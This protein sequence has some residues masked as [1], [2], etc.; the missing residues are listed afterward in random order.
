[1]LS[2]A[3]GDEDRLAEA[4]AFRIDQ[5]HPLLQDTRL[6]Q[7]FD[8][9]PAGVDG[10]A[11]A[12]GQCLE[13]FTGIGLQGPQQQPVGIINIFHNRYYYPK[14]LAIPEPFGPIF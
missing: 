13:R 4:D 11:G 5:G 10:N 6:F 8:P 2:G 9:P 7:P 14:I 3:D 12:G 1:M